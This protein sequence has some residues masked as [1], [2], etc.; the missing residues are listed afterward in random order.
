VEHHRKIIRE[1]KNFLFVT[2]GEIKDTER[3]S[4]KCSEK[5]EMS[6]RLGTQTRKRRF[7]E[8]KYSLRGL[9]DDVY[10]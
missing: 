10:L 9:W 2:R 3:G 4:E 7:K 6:Y 1:G 5:R 8:K